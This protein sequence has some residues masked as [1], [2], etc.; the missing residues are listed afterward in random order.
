MKIIHKYSCGID[1]AYTRVNGFLEK[2]AKDYSQII[3]NPTKKWNE[4]KEEMEFKFGVSGI[5]VKGNISLYNEG[6]I[7]QGDLPFPVN[8]MKK[9]IEKIIQ[10]KLEEMFK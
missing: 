8:L 2:L 5:D 3:E 6:L 4:G 10:G 9:D 7:L 1:E